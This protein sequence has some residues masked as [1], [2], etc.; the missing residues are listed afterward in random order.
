MRELSYVTV[1]V[2]LLSVAGV[3][4]SPQYD[5]SPVVYQDDCDYRG[6]DDNTA[7]FKCGS[8]CVSWSKTCNCSGTIITYEL[9]GIPPDTAALRPSVKR[10]VTV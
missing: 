1:C 5:D 10:I 6:F 9:S 3:T 8:K 2:L 4:S 7:N